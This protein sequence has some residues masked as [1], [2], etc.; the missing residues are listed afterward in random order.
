E[1]PLTEREMEILRLLCKN[2]SRKEIAQILFLS[3][4]TIKRHLANMMEKTGF[5]TTMA[6]AVYMISN[7]WINP[8]I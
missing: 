2:Y 5:N 7:G 4:N 1:A 6:L 3:E 8:N